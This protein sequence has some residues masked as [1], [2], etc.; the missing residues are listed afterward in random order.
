MNGFW[1]NGKCSGVKFPIYSVRIVCDHFFLCTARICLLRERACA[2]AFA[3]R[4]PFFNWPVS[5]CVYREREREMD[6]LQ[7][8]MLD[9]ECWLLLL[10]L[11]LLHVLYVNILNVCVRAIGERATAK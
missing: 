1:P 7:Y 2:L 3:L 11:L 9:A 4:S 5:I 6:K 8:N 10:L